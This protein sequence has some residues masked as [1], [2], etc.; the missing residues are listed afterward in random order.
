MTRE[1]GTNVKSECMEG[2]RRER[3]SS[4]KEGMKGGDKREENKAGGSRK[5]KEK[6]GRKEKQDKK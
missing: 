5:E 1:E 6:P 3:K 2:E 4:A